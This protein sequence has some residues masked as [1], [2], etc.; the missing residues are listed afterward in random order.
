MSLPNVKY[1]YYEIINK[2][3]QEQ[4]ENNES[5]LRLSGV[6]SQNFQNTFWKD[7]WLYNKCRH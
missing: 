5:S 4:I 2:Q 7:V 1:T 3:A 6:R